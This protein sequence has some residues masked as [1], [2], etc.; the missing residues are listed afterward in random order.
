MQ[1]ACDRA[2]RKLEWEGGRIPSAPW[3]WKNIPIKPKRQRWETYER[4]LAELER[5]CREYD[6]IFIWRLMRWGQSRLDV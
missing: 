5:C 3:L 4:N 2:A 6:S 1:N